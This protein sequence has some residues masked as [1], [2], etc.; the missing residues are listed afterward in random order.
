[1]SAKNELNSQQIIFCKEY[2]K[3]FN[4]TQAA[5]RAGYA[6]GSAA[7]TSSR[8]ISY[9]NIKSYITELQA[10]KSKKTEVTAERVLLELSRIGFSNIVDYLNEGFQ[11][12]DLHKL[13]RSKCA[14]IKSIEVTETTI[15][16]VTKTQAK[17]T[18]HNKLEAI[19]KIAKHI[20]FFEKDNNQKGL[21]ISAT[22]FVLKVKKDLESD[23]EGHS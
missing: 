22:N 7:E 20:G 18:M 12:K 1:M 3:D 10:G 9:A 19:D 14:A 15:E 13:K 6:E 16:G 5:I 21:D 11:I 2:V 23:N 4:G 17:F 8:L